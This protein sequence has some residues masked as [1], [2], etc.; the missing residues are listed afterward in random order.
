[1]GLHDGIAR[2]K[3]ERFL[4]Q[5]AD[6]L[7]DH[8]VLELLLY[9]AIPRRDTNE[10]AHR[11]IQ[12]FGTLD[13]VF[14]APPEALMQV[15]GIGENAAV[16]LNLVPAA[17]RCA[18]RSVSAERILNSVERCGAYFM[19]LL[20]GQRRE[21]L[22]QVCLDGK[23]KVLS[24]KC[25]SQGSADM[26]SLSIRQVGGE[27]PAVRAPQAWCWA[28]ITPAAWRCRRRRTGPPPCRCGTLWPPWTS[29]CWTTSSW[30]TVISSP[31]RP[32]AFCTADPLK[33]NSPS[34][35]L[36]PERG[37]AM[38]SLYKI[39]TFVSKFIFTY[40]IFVVK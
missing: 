4:K 9:Y 30:P 14:Q 29:A 31:W 37:A 36:H 28:T 35:P 21:L 19:D 25:L 12:H 39:R 17:Q 18:R 15:S 20:D 2:R 22:Y 13:A 3:R 10:L 27:R 34:A 7:A 24:C 32:A 23:G 16:L 33:E 11:L 5:G 40:G 26:T 1:M 6:G 38:F 8:E